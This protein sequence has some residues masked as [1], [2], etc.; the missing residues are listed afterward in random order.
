MGK[1]FK[2]GE[3]VFHLDTVKERIKKVK[4]VSYREDLLEDD[5]IDV[6]YRVECE[7]GNK[8]Y[9]DENYLAETQIELANMFLESYGFSNELRFRPVCEKCT[10][11]MTE[12][13]QP[14]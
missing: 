10:R 2:I 13:Y 3:Y 4:V 12:T 9:T 1:K 8:I 14:L 6:S 11:L 7:D 5:S